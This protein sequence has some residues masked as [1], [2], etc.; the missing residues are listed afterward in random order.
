LESS[1]SSPRHTPTD[2]RNSD[3]RY[4]VLSGK[5]RLISALENMRSEHT[6]DI[7]GECCVVMRFPVMRGRLGLSAVQLGVPDVLYLR[8]PSQ[9]GEPVVQS[10]S[11]GVEAHHAVRAAAN[12]GFKN[13]SMHLLNVGAPFLAKRNKPALV[14]GPDGLHPSSDKSTVYLC[15]SAFS[16]TDGF[17]APQGRD[18]V[19]GELGDFFP[20]FHVAY[21]NIEEAVT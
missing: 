19:V 21:S 6:D 4:S 3:F 1:S 8:P 5:S 18:A 9:V 15:P 14:S 12:E 11:V 17:N 20:L 13:K 2:T 7:S 16:R 10:I